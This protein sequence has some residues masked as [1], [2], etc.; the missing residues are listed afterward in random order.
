M[1]KK[2]YEKNGT[3][4]DVV[5]STRIRFA[6]NLEEYPFPIRCSRDIRQKYSSVLVKR[7]LFVILTLSSAVN[8]IFTG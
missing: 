7:F 1:E 3:D 5:I 8:S 2:W 4:G 6:R